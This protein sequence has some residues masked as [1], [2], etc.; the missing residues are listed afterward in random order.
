MSDLIQQMK[1]NAARAALKYIEDDQIL[2][3]GSGSTISI[4]IAELANIKHKISGAVASSKATEELLKQYGIPVLD[5]NNVDTLPLYIDGTDAYNSLRQLVKGGCGYLVREKILAY[6]SKKFICIADARKQ[7]GILGDVPVPVE[8]VPM[9]RSLVARELVRLGGR[10]E[11]RNNYI[12]DNGN[13]ILD[14]HGWQIT[15]PIEFEAKLKQITGVID[16][17]IFAKR[18][19]DVIIIGNEDKVT[20][21]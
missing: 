21:L 4:F 3:I 13:I 14:I 18:T 9:A 20:Q 19:A 15:Q 2:G 11:Y 17:G 7:P 5:F 8:V 10:P 16:S 1:Q 12:T 6:A